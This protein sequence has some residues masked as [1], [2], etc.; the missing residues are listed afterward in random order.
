MN[1]D[2]ESITS[3][4]ESDDS[5][6]WENSNAYLQ[7][8]RYLYEFPQPFCG[9]EEENIYD[10]IEDLETA[11]LNNRVTAS[12]QVTLLQKLVKGD[13]KSS[14]SD[15]RSLDENFKYLKLVFGNPHAIWM[16]EKNNFLKRSKDEIMNWTG[17]GYFSRQRKMMLVKV[18]AF[19]RSAE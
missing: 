19:L 12:S 8:H 10:F 4:T 1:F 18:C 5:S 11:I 15:S 13:A 7:E 3:E 14:V 17:F 9:K 2:D 16:K 6:L